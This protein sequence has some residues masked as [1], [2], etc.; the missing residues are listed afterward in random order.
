MA[1]Y[2]SPVSS[3]IPQL[4]AAAALEHFR[5]AEVVAPLTNRQYEGEAVAGNTVKVTTLTIGDDTPVQDYKANGHVHTNDTIGSATQDI[6]INQEKV[7]AFGVDDVDR[8]QAAGS[9]ETVT[10]DAAKLLTEDAEAYIIATMSAGGTA[11]G[12][13]AITTPDAAVDKVGELRKLLTKSNVPAGDRYLIINPEFLE[14][15]LK[16]ASKLSSVNTSGVDSGLR[17]AVVG[18]LSNFTVVESNMLVN[19]DRPAAI[20]LH[21]SAVAYVNQIQTVEA[22]RSQTSF[23]DVL[24]MLHVY[25]A[26]VLRPT[27]VQVYL[28][29]AGS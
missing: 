25:G 17:D 24:R 7:I 12:T 4:W 15:L 19:S 16:S 13:T 11:A 10:A 8:V 28:G 3:F 29:A 14:L 1:A 26:K 6:L 18:R 9:M 23:Q 22:F 5:P 2:S 27:A 20:A 21:T